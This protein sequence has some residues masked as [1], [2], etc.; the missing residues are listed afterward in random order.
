MESASEVIFVLLLN[1]LLDIE[2]IVFGI[3]KVPTKAQLSNASFINDCMLV[4]IVIAP[5]QHVV[6]G[7]ALLTQLLVNEVG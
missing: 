6:D 4:L 7:L 5:E 2:V 3:V 1:A